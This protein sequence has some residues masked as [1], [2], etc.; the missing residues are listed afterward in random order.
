MPIESRLQGWLHAVEQGA[1]AVW[2]R[3]LLLVSAVVVI[4]ALWFLLRFNGFSQPEAMDQAQIARQLATGQGYTTL[5]ARP[6]ALHLTL[7]RTGAVP[8]PL[9]D[10]TQAPLGPVL[11][12][13]A[14]RLTGTASHPGP[15]AVET[16]AERVIALTGFAFFAASL[17]LILLLLRRLFGPRLALLGTGLVIVSDLFWRFSFS[18]LPQMPMLFF[19]SGALLCLAAAMDAQAG[20]QTRRTTF[21]LLGAALLLGLVTLGDGRGVWIFGGFWVFAVL[22]LRPGLV[23]A[24][25]MPAAFALP[26]LPWAAHNWLA[27]R[28]PL[29]LPFYELYRP[30]GT[31]RLA[32]LAD[33]E[34]L[35]RFR[36]PDFFRNTLTQA[37]DLIATLPAALG[38]SV[39]AAAF[40]LAVFAHTPARWQAA[41]FRWAI[42]LMWLGAMAGMSV[43][44]VYGP[45]AAG[46]LQVLFVPLAGAYGLAFL[47][48]LL[49][50]LELRQ[51]YIRAAAIIALF[52]LT[53]A[54]LLIGLRT[55][56]KRFNW[57][58]YLPPLVARFADWIGPGEALASDIPW[59]TAWYSGRVS[60]LLPESIEQ[61]DLINSERLLGAPLVALYLTPFSGEGRTYADIIN[62][63]YR[64]WSRFVLR[65]VR[66]EDLRNWTLRTG[67]ALPIDGGSMIY[68]DRPRWQ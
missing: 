63:R 50:R 62:G 36:A 65:E 46:Q 49:D 32:W 2:L 54:P 14:M 20:R 18:G 39:A 4:G 42:V 34:P 7:A 29:G 16:P 68:A 59:A 35:L 11:S 44:P 17:V 40:A 6:L 31:D 41:Q 43:F 9:K 22:V 56:S 38:G 52:A 25:G 8:A 5:Y 10:S 23:A 15:E 53:A 13:A 1:G 67:V 61:F 12:A 58:P 24:A 27:L 30:N 3:R 33:F 47:I 21:L 66:P 64:E 45:V 28:Q 60:L 51:N 55:G 48:S 57:P 26:L 19:F 37:L